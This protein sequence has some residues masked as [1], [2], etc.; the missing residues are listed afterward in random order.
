MIQYSNLFFFSLVIKIHN[1]WSMNDLVCNL[2]SSI[3]RTLLSSLLLHQLKDELWPKP[4]GLSEW[5]FCRTCTHSFVIQSGYYPPILKQD[6]KKLGD[7]KKLSTLDLK[8][9]RAGVVLL[10]YFGL[11]SHTYADQLDG[12]HRQIFLQNKLAQTKTR[13]D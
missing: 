10:F 6:F 4:L 8:K 13:L 2:L 3:A 1:C 12:L 9:F 11:L 5:S 7:K